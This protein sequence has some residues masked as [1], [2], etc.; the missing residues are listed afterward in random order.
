MKKILV[1]VVMGSASDLPVMEETLKLL[2]IFK[3]PYEVGIYSAHRS[4]R[5]TSAFAKTSHARGL[6]IIVAGAGGAAHLAGVIAAETILPVI[7]VPLDSSPLNGFD[8]LLATA[9]MPGGVPV[10]TMAIGKSGAKNAAVLAAQIL[11]LKYPEIQ[12]RLLAYKKGLVAQTAL[13]SNQLKKG[14]SS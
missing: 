9:Q 12:K 3:I 2:D 5:R 6:E 4:P 8:A 1:G 14:R 11:A 7:G 10:A 13:K